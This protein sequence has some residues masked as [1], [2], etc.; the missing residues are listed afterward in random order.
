M[1]VHALALAGAS[2][3]WASSRGAVGGGRHSRLL[4][5]GLA[6][7]LAVL[8]GVPSLK[9]AASAIEVAAGEVPGVT[10]VGDRVEL[11]GG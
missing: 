5:A 2:L 4:L 8:A 10:V 7:G 3:G 11:F 6:A 9:P 1:T